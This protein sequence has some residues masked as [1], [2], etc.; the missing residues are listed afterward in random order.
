MQIT[1]LT[2]R[3]AGW[4]VD[5]MPAACG[6][7]VYRGTGERGNREWRRDLGSRRIPRRMRLARAAGVFALALWGC[8]AADA[9]VI[10][11]VGSDGRVS[12]Q[13]QRC[14]D[15]AR[16][17]IVEPRDEPASNADAR[18]S[19]APTRS[20]HDAASGA[21]DDAAGKSADDST[22]TT[23]A[24]SATVAMERFTD[25]LASGGLGPEMIVV[26]GGD[27]PMGCT[28]SAW[29]CVTS[30]RPRHRVQVPGFAIAATEVTFAQ[31]DRCV[32]AGRCLPAHD[33]GWGRGERPVIHVHWRA[34]QAYADWLSEETGKRYRLPSEAEWEYAARAGQY[35]E[36]AWDDADYPY[37]K[38]APAQVSDSR[39]DSDITQTAAVG[40][41]PPNAFGLHDMTG[42]VAEWTL[43]C[44]H[45]SY[46]GAPADGRAWGRGR[47]GDCGRRVTRGGGWDGPAADVAERVPESIDRTGNALGFRVVQVSIEAHARDRWMHRLKTAI[48]LVLPRPRAA[49]GGGDGTIEPALVRVPGGRFLQGASPGN[50]T[51]AA[52]NHELPQRE[53]AIRSFLLARHEVTRREFAAFVAATGYRTDAERDSVVLDPPQSPRNGYGCNGEPGRSWREPGFAQDD[54]HPATCLSWNDAQAYIAWLSYQTGRPYRLPTESEFEYAMRAGTTGEW[55]WSGDP[56]RHAN[57]ADL[58]TFRK[59][60]GIRGW[61]VNECEDGFEE[62]APVGRFAANAFGL[63]DMLG[64]VAEWVQ[65]CMDSGYDERLPRDGRAAEEDPCVKRGLR[66]GGWYHP[67]SGLRSAARSA[68]PPMDRS[69]ATGFRVALGSP[70]RFD[71]VALRRALLDALFALEPEVPR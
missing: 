64:N 63:H 24:A 31:Y 6:P 27:L 21:A 61:G 70:Y 50:E 32:D 46:H 19:T 23:P 14:A 7:V 53:I 3:L 26:P 49:P 29:S 10:R 11:C 57:Q 56:C 28:T 55:A 20:D 18:Q 17:E 13:Q 34:A 45:P 22:A 60:Q 65:D 48:R 16:S 36:H 42:N 59:H 52:S 41:Y 68:A 69:F 51:F 9:Q 2:R 15:D 37:P 33:A 39:R 71:V 1:P 43:D 62:T 58:T 35:H 38:P 4:F 5:A 66:G 44:F 30:A 8:A 67:S 12:Y 25:R 54:D 47:D 40:T